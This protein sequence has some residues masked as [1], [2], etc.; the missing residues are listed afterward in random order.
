[1][2]VVCCN[3]GVLY[4]GFEVQECLFR[5]RVLSVRWLYWYHGSDGIVLLSCSE[6]SDILLRDGFE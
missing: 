4:D 3:V 6:K 2:G 5:A 1:M